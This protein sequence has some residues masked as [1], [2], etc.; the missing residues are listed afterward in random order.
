VTELPPRRLPATDTDVRVFAGTGPCNPESIRHAAGW[1]DDASPNVIA[2]LMGIVSTLAW[3]VQ[4]LEAS[5]AELKS[6]GTTDRTTRELAEREVARVISTTLFA[7]E[8][9]GPIQ[10]SFVV[11]SIVKLI[12]AHCHLGLLADEVV[13]K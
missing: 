7:G 4:Q 11:S 13:S 3:N 9:D 2:K 12:G 5:V 6:H 8:P 1:L 10:A